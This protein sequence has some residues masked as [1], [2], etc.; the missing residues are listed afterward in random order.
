M[1][2]GHRPR[3]YPIVPVPHPYRRQAHPI[4]PAGLPH[5]I[6]RPTPYHRQAYPLRPDEIRVAGTSDTVVLRA[7]V[8]TECILILKRIF[9][10]FQWTNPSEEV[11]K[12]NLEKLFARRL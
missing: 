6:G 12:R 2:E 10:L 7:D 8:R 5:I 11:L 1:A 3:A 9:A 4:S